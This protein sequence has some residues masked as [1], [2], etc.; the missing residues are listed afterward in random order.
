VPVLVHDRLQPRPVA[1]GDDAERTVDAKREAELS[2]VEEPGVGQREL[3][4]GVDLADDHAAVGRG[5]GSAR[6]ASTSVTLP[7]LSS[8]YNRQPEGGPP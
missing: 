8:R 6:G 5:P 2:C 1:D 4:P 7:W 3:G